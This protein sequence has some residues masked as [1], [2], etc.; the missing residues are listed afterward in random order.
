MRGPDGTDIPVF[1]P[2]SVGPVLEAGCITKLLLTTELGPSP[3]TPAD[4]F[5][6]YVC[7]PR[8]SPEAETCWPDSLP[9]I[10][11]SRHYLRTVLKGIRFSPASAM[12]ATTGAEPTSSELSQLARQG[13][14]ELSAPDR[15]LLL[16]RVFETFV[17]RSLSIAMGSE[18]MARQLVAWR[19]IDQIAA[20]F[21]LIMPESYPGDNLLRA[22]VLVGG[23]P[24]DLQAEALK[25][26]L[27]TLSNRLLI[28][29][30]GWRGMPNNSRLLVGLCRLSGLAEPLAMQNLVELSRRSLTLTAVVNDLFRAAVL[31]MAA[32]I[33]S[34][35]LKADDRID[36]DWP[37]RHEQTP[38]KFAAVEG[39]VDLVAALLNSGA[40]CNDGELVAAAICRPEAGLSHEIVKL[41]VGRGA[42]LEGYP[43]SALQA[44]IV[45]DDRD[46]IDFLVGEGSDLNC[47]R[48]PEPFDGSL[49][50]YDYD[51]YAR[52]HDVG[53]L[54]LAAAFPS[55]LPDSSLGEM[56]LEEKRALGLCQKLLDSYGPQMELSSRSLGDAMIMSAARGYTQIL[57]YFRDR[58]S[59]PLDAINGFITPLYA[60]VR[61]NHVEACRLLLDLGASLHVRPP[62]S[63]AGHPAP[64]L[65]HIA[66]CQNYYEMVE[67]LLQHDAAI[68]ELYN[69]VLDDVE[70]YPFG[71]LADPEMINP[72]NITPL[73]AA[74][75][76]RHWGIGLLLAISGATATASDL[77]AAAKGGHVQMVEKLLEMGIR[78]DDAVA[79]GT[80][81][82]QSALSGRHWPVAKS[83]LAAGATVSPSHSATLWRIPDAAFIQKHPFLTTRPASLG[84][85]IEGRS[86]LENAVLS[87]DRDVI[88]LAF[89]LDPI[90][91]ES[92][93]MCA[94]IL[95]AIKS[96]LPH[97][98]YVLQ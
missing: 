34:R 56:H 16:S 52:L 98:D 53:C 24:S 37:V 26:L 62:Y 44:A 47:R 75:L 43:L 85:D 3:E 95:L 81:A 55:T 27:Y 40:S 49:W 83:L 69:G 32:D 45:M 63:H 50:E 67:V 74:I 39:C 66:A 46:L 13:V 89:S 79:D 23:R 38:L 88:A 68:N 60:A 25:V 12:A 14:M 82:F 76:S 15:A 70:K 59:A 91:Y 54:G 4:D 36:P 30:D 72:Q 84:R 28:D 61:W 78:P 42:S 77:F 33:V 35:L 5:P 21:D 93:A 31:A 8:S 9:W 65:L 48:H 97:S 18:E 73:S 7:T 57:L 51:V 29:D 71:Y 87:G 90:A 1:Y 94:A 17:R 92:G 96:A 80:S 10:Q 64:P 11:F 58:F 86:Y 6:V 20:R 19:S 22:T 2:V 41:L